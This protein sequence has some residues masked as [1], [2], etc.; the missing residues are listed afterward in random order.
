MAEKRRQSPQEANPHQK[1]VPR[2]LLQHCRDSSSP[3]PPP[4]CTLP[5]GAEDELARAGKMPPDVISVQNDDAA[6]RSLLMKLLMGYQLSQVISVA[7]KL[8]LSDFLRDG[9]MGVADLAQETA[10]QPTAL[11]RLLR[12][13]AAAG[14]LQEG[15]DHA[16]RLTPLGALLRSDLPDSLWATAS[17]QTNDTTWNR[18]GNLLQQVRTGESESGNSFVQRLDER[19]DEA[20]LF[21]QYMTE[22]A[23]VRAA[24]VLEGYD[25]TDVATIADIGG[26][27][28]RLLASI[29][30]KYPAARGLLFDLPKVVAG[31]R[32]LL[33][34]EG[35]AGRCEIIGGDF[36][37]AVPAGRTVYLLSAV[38]HDWDDDRALAILRNCRQAAARSGKILLVERVVPSDDVEQAL[39]ILL[40]DL[41]MM[42]GPGGRERTAEEFRTLL[43]EAS[44]RLTRLIPLRSPYHLVEGMPV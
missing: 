13:L 35:V 7:A 21:N 1:I 31:A 33:E 44:F 16:F 6:L 4:P 9:P 34:A 11:G 39:D 32:D 20:A 14:L 43:A 5:A 2:D 10:T 28:G 29:L 8:R 42:L 27:H 22:R 19:P 24:A 26:G 36:F 40:S 17:F 12:T 23:D 41:N 38:I 30:K 3:R 37:A 18:W 25:F 15:R